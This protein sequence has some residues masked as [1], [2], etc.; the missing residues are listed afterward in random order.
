MK[1]CSYFFGFSSFGYF[2][3]LQTVFI[4]SV[5]NNQLLDW[6]ENELI[7][8]LSFIPGFASVLPELVAK[9]NAMKEKY[10][11]AS[12]PVPSNIKV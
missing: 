7:W 11:T 3:L 2:P 1:V 5:C 12:T 4:I 10:L 9:L 8:I 6:I